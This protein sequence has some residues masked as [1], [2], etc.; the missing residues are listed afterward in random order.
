[1]Y[2]ECEQTDV[3]VHSFLHLCTHLPT[4]PST[5]CWLDAL[6]V[7]DKSNCIAASFALMDSTDDVIVETLALM[8]SADHIIAEALA[9]SDSTDHIIVD[10]L[11]LT[12]S[13]DYVIAETLALMDRANHSIA[14]GEMIY[15][16]H[17]WLIY[18]SNMILGFFLHEHS[19]LN[20]VFKQYFKCC[21]CRRGLG[22]RYHGHGNPILRE[23]T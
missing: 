5:V 9:L 8:G 14:E 15:C 23:R 13:T 19:L 18:I 3:N 16:H 21:K 2:S 17:P 1:M 4:C 10:A 11:A 6:P 22:N 7:L 20:T 12:D